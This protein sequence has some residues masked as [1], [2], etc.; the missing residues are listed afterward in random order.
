MNE[1]KGKYMA[2]FRNKPL[3]IAII[4]L[5]VLV[6]LLFITAGSAGG[7]NFLGRIFSSVQQGV[8]QAASAVGGWF[9]SLFSG[10]ALESENAALKAQV[11]ELEKQILAY[12]ELEK[13][14]ERLTSLLDVKDSVAGWHSVTARVIGRSPGEW[15]SGFTINV[16]T[17]DGITLN[18][19]VITAG[20]LV[21][22]VVEVTPTYAKVVAIVDSSSGVSALIE[23]T[24]ENGVVRGSA[25]AALQLKYID[26]G[27][28]VAAGDR[29]LTS[30]L[31]GLFP[32]GLVIGTVTD[33][34]DNPEA[35][36]KLIHV[37]SAVN[38]STLE[39]VVVLTKTES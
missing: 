30:G 19:P 20:G 7:N 10:S 23:R 12:S 21:G 37:E 27:S 35:G 22:K 39:E 34:S 8:H 17:D 31:D 26:S 33:V 13:E 15:Y 38:F 6:I 36:G 1:T 29:V 5:L 32:K 28:N 24:R 11:A 2:F 16:G 3:F 14:N 4:V 25:S 9:S 18:A